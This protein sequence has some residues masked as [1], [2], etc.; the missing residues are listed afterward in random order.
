MPA[1]MTSL[2]AGRRQQKAQLGGL[3]WVGGGGWNGVGKWVKVSGVGAGVWVV[4]CS[5]L[6]WWWCWYW[7]VGGVGW[8]GVGRTGNARGRAG[9]GA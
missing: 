4:G 8:G 1:P 9:A 5:G 6:R 7:W 2:P 3:G